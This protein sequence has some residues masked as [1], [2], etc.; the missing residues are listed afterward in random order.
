MS[1][2]NDTLWHRYRMAFPDDGL[3]MMYWQQDSDAQLERLM[4]RAIKDG[5]PI[6]PDDL[7]KAQGMNP[8]GP[9]DVA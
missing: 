6:T 8:T 5:R 1:Y 7:L 3:P 9:D 2:I 4:E